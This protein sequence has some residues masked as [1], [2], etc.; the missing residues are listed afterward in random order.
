MNETH[1]SSLEIIEIDDN[2]PENYLDKDER[3]DGDDEMNPER[4][5]PSLTFFLAFDLLGDTSKKKSIFALNIE[6]NY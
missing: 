1:D 6:D 2:N 5:S 4:P 3:E